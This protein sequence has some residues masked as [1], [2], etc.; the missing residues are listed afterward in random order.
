MAEI[1]TERIEGHYEVQEMEYGKVYKWCPESVVVECECGE[2]LALTGSVTTCECG[3]QHRV[4]TREEVV[5]H[6]MPENDEILHP[7]RYDVDREDG[8]IPF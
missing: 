2:R 7:W 8:G 1:T 4:D 5:A 6:Q 3:A